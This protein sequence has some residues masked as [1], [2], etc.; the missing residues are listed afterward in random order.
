MRIICS[1]SYENSI[2]REHSYVD[3]MKQYTYGYYIKCSLYEDQTRG[4]EWHV[5]S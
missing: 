4:F 2:I 5:W 3:N 1:R